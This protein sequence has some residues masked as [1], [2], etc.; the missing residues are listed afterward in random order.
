MPLAH[1]KGRLFIGG[2]IDVIAAASQQPLLANRRK[3][4]S[5]RTVIE[6][7]WGGLRLQPQVYLD[8]VALAGADALPV[9]AEGK[10]L[11]IIGSNDWI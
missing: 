8:R 1:P 7:G 10:P 2:K 4:S 5:G 11:F 3:K 6:V 9:W